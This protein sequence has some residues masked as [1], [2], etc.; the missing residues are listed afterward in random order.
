MRKGSFSFR[1]SL[2]MSGVASVTGSPSVLIHKKG[3]LST[4][5][6]KPKPLRAQLL[7]LP[8]PNTQTP[9]VFRQGTH[10]ETCAQLCVHETQSKRTRSLEPNCHRPSKTVRTSSAS[11]RMKSPLLWED[12]VCHRSVLNQVV[13]CLC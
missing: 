5:G 1:Q 11:R 3:F 4:D 8:R 9:R 7:G 10:N 12:F 6:T 2:L 13:L